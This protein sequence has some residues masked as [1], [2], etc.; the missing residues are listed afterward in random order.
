[1]GILGLTGLATAARFAIWP[2]ID[3]YDAEIKAAADKY[4]IL[5]DLVKAMVATES[6][7][8]PDAVRQEPQI[9]DASYGL[10]QVLTGT[11]AD[12]GYSQADLQT[13]QGGLDAGCKYLAHL[14][15][16]FN[17]DEAKAIQAYNEGPGNVRAG[18]HDWGYW[19]RVKFHQLALEA[20]G[21]G[22]K[23]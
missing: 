2:N 15:A 18:H 20:S 6:A 7:F 17:G 8:K 19:F 14:F 21:H 12:L 23:A 10:L 9:H 22:V 16:E 5:P 13:V 1:M 11:A 3:K 4:G